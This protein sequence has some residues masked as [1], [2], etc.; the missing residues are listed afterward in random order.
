MSV[1]SE[2]AGVLMP[3]VTNL[4]QRFLFMMSMLLSTCSSHCRH[5]QLLD[6]VVGMCEEVGQEEVTKGAPKLL[7]GL[8]AGAT[9][10]ARS[11]DTK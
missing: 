10:L 7:E 6:G 11:L 9:S 4:I 5:R 2:V 3:I 1:S 8:R